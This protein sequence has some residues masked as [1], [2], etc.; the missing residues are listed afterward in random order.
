MIDFI[1]TLGTL[2]L[3]SRSD[4]S[5]IASLSIAPGDDASKFDPDKPL[6]DNIPQATLRKA[7]VSRRSIWPSVRI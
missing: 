5:A 4:A 7:A 1:C 3:T 2:H 6:P